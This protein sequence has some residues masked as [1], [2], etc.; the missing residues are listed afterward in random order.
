MCV[1]VSHELRECVSVSV[2]DG[3][4]HVHLHRAREALR[5][6][7]PIQLKDSTFSSVLKEDGTT[8]KWLLQLLSSLRLELMTNENRSTVHSSNLPQSQ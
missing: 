4:C 6:C 5:Q 3:M 1:C 2:S 7:L 8:K